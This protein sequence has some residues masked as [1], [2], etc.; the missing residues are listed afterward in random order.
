MEYDPVP[1]LKRKHFE[2]GM[3]QSRKSVDANDLV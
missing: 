1:E 2:E 3:K